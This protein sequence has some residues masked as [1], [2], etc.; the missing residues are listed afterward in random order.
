MTESSAPVAAS[1]EL[2]ATPPL[3]QVERVVDTFVAPSKTFTDILRSQS[4]WLPFLIITLVG[5]AFVFTIDKRVGWDQVLENALKASPAQA[6]KIASAPAEQ[7]ATI[8]SSMLI[9]YKGFSYGFPLTVL[10]FWV[11]GA[12]V[13]LATLNFVFGGRAKFG[14][15]FAVFVY[16]GLPGVLKSILTIIVLFVG[17]SA[18][19]FQLQ[20]PVGTNVGYYLPAETS[21]WLMNLATS[22]DV[23]TIWTIIL[24]VIGC[25]IVAKVKRS[26]A[27]TAVVG[28]WILLTLLGVVVAAVQG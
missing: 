24:L 20:N 27:A 16:A 17:L 6:E 8:R 13:M 10:L 15:L 21:R 5:Y 1:P 4:W 3:S 26:T 7:Q 28:W 11:I 22:I 25:S 18:E 14:Q 12:A 19:S 2:P 23:L 9:G